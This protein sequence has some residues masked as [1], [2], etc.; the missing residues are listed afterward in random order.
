MWGEI[1]RPDS[2]INRIT[3]WLIT[4]GIVIVVGSILTLVT[5]IFMEGWPYILISIL[6]IIVIK[7]TH[8]L[9]FN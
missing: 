5:F 1:D 6:F 7:L 9:L 4:I 2:W 8:Y 3:D